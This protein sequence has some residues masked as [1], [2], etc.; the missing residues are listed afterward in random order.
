M[1]LLREFPFPRELGQILVTTFIV[2]F[3][4]IHLKKKEMYKWRRMNFKDMLW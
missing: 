3:Y 4:I 2:I 1:L